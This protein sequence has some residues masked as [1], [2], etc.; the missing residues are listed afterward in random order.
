M[1]NKRRLKT[2]VKIALLLL[3]EMIIISQL[4]FVGLKINDL[5]K[6]INEPIVIIETRCFYEW[7]YKSKWIARNYK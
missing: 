3:P 1:K 5:I 2:W 7:T 6:E 4:F